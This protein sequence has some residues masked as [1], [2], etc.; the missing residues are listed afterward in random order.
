MRS[1][2]GFWHSFK[3]PEVQMPSDDIVPNKP[4]LD[5]RTVKDSNRYD[6][7]FSSELRTSQSIDWYAS[8]QSRTVEING[9]QVTV[10]FVGRKGRRARIAIVAPAGSIF[11]ALDFS[12]SVRSP[13]GS[14]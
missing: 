10:R 14:S 5:R 7:S 2:P 11:C 9:V 8:G 3:P 1:K 6:D 4:S 12:E 13:M